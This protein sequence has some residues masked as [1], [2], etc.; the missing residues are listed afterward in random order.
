MYID[1]LIC[2]VF[3]LNFEWSELALICKMYIIKE[4][5]F[6]EIFKWNKQILNKVRNDS[7]RKD[8][9]AKVCVKSAFPFFENW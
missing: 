8:V 6:K 3:V 7:I 4:Y 9:E 1:E 2:C 5:G